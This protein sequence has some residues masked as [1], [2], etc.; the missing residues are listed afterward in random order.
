MA[1]GL[2]AYPIAE[3][4]ATCSLINPLPTGIA[5]T[6][7]LWNSPLQPAGVQDCNGRLDRVVANVMPAVNELSTLA[8]WGYCSMTV[9]LHRHPNLLIEG[10]LSPTLLPHIRHLSPLHAVHRRDSSRHAVLHV[11]RHQVGRP[12]S[13]MWH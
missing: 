5:F 4:V 6:T 7:S 9:T 3:Y 12:L 2:S 1:D 8:S 13:S 11:C 10:A